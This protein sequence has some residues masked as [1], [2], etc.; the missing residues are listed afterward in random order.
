MKILYARG[1]VTVER[2]RGARGGDFG[3]NIVTDEKGKVLTRR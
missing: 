2:R 1:D 3:A